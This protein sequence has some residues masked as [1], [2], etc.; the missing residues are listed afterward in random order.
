MRGGIVRE[1]EAAQVQLSEAARRAQERAAAAAARP[2]RVTRYARAQV[3]I[4]E[5]SD[6]EDEA[7]DGELL[8]SA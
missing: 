2:Q 3:T 5:H 1:L 4:E 8:W 7:G 6:H